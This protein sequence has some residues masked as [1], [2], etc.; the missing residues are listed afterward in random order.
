MSL[1]N[2]LK[3]EGK[4]IKCLDKDLRGLMERAGDRVNL[5]NVLLVQLIREMKQLNEV[6]TPKPEVNVEMYFPKTKAEKKPEPVKKATKP[7][8]I[9]GKF[10]KNKG[11]KKK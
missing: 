2:I 5:T 9:F 4:T 7:R 3:L 10:G 8:G 1:D 11:D 6:L